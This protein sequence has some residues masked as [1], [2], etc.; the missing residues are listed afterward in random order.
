MIRRHLWLVARLLLGVAC[1]VYI[2]SKVHLVHD[3]ITLRTKEEISGRIVSETKDAVTFRR[4]GSTEIETIPTSEIADGG[5]VKSI[6]TL[7]KALSPILFLLSLAALG[8]GWLVTVIRWQLLTAA[9]GMPIP[10][11]LAY[12]LTYIGFFFS[13]VLPGATGG[14][15][16]KAVMAAKGRSDK[17][18]MVV[19]V[20]V[21]RI[22][23]L[24]AMAILAGIA[25]LFHLG[26][27]RFRALILAVVW[28]LGVSLVGAAIFFSRRLRRVFFLDR[29][30]EKL[31][32]K[33]LLQDVDRAFFLYRYHKGA[34]FAAF[35]LSFLNLFFLT[36][37]NALIGL[38]LN[39]DVPLYHYLIF[40]PIASIVTAIP[41]LPAGWGLGEM[42]YSYLFKTVGA[43]G[44]TGVTLSVLYRISTVAW[45]LLGG[46]FFMIEKRHDAGSASGKVAAPSS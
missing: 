20:F 28:I 37:N 8:A 9:R 5:I 35:G 43:S 3:S 23:G 6:P 4:E 24:V 2:L 29:L 11:G 7:L 42:A 21:D 38:A 19:S 22:I 40:A 26:D 18:D 1:F 39:A 17:T 16:V 31:P 27:P 41:L 30:L 13:N 45:S 44:T 33:R 12:R 46:I 15:V 36:T 25:L 32:A 10:F 14:D 34:V